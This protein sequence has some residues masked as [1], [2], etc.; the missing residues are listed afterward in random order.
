MLSSI[1]ISATGVTD[2]LGRGG[3]LSQVESKSRPLS[4]VHRVGDGFLSTG[5]GKLGFISQKKIISLV[6]S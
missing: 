1:D 5:R 3:M 6:V 2:K 4:R